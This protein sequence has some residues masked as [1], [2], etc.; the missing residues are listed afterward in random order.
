M[1]KLASSRF[2]IR[3]D[4]L[5][6]LVVAI[7]ASGPIA[8]WNR[9]IFS[10][11]NLP[12]LAALMLFSVLMIWRDRVPRGIGFPAFTACFALF[13]LYTLSRV[14]N[15]S[16][17]SLAPA[18]PDSI[19]PGIAHVVDLML[20]FS[21]FVFA[22]M[23]YYRSMRF[24]VVL[25]LMICGYIVA[26]VV[27][28]SLDI[29]G[30]QEG[31][32]LSPGFA[33]LTFLPFVFLA[34]DETRRMW[35]PTVLFFLCLFWLALIGARTAV[36]SLLIFYVVMRAWPII[37]R[38]RMIY[39]GTFWAAALLLF[40]LNV[41]Y[42]LYA[43]MDAPALL[44][45]IGVKVFEK[46]LGTRIDIWVHLLSLIAER[47]LLG[48]GTD[49]ATVALVPLSHLEFTMRR[50]DLNANSM[51]YELLYRL[52]AIGLIG[53]FVMMF[54]VWKTFWWGRKDPAVRVAGAFLLCVLFFAATSDYLVLTEL[55]LRSGFAWI[56]LGIGAGA[57][58]RARNQATRQT[59]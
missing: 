34:T 7:G 9:Y 26:Y 42:L 38:N 50:D 48:F 47:P 14:D 54:S 46:R 27:R 15:W 59:R 22:A 29:L 21:L 2:A 4:T 24:S 28:N 49:H 20:F 39:A 1:L 11:D 23:L 51:Y 8:L 40:A 33:L 31:Y 10:E 52:G 6:A 5:V 53:F 55:R 35:I 37:T 30:L 3:N 36:V 13:T 18:G 45:G 25:W 43:V 41:A 56:L 17:F 58:L 16:G 57:A 19:R 32:H 44:D 12:I